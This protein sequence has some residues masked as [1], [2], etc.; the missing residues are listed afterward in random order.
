MLRLTLILLAL[1]LPAL[2]PA[3]A[4]ARPPRLFPDHASAVLE[5][6]PKGYARITPIARAQGAS[7]PRARALLEASAS[8]GDS[9]LAAR[10][11]AMLTQLPP[12]TDPQSIRRLQAF[13]AQ[14]RHDF[15]A[16]VSH[17]DA[18]LAQDPRDASARLS[19]AQVQ[20]VRGRLDLARR[21]CLGLA[22]GIDSGEGLICLAAWSL[23]RG[24]AA[25]A[26]LL[27]DRW[28]A[29]AGPT[30]P[31]RRFVLILRAEA[32]ARGGQSAD[33]W[34][35]L[36]LARAPQDVRSLAAYARYLRA[37]G[38]PRDALALLETAP[39]ADGLLLQ[40][41]LAAQALHTPGAPALVA[42]QA[43]RFREARRVGATIELRD[44]AEFLLATT[45]DASRPLALALENFKQQR[46][47]ED[48]DILLRSAR[49]AGRP[50]ALAPLQ[51]WARSQQLTLP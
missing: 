44:E 23:R 48:V 20:L 30:D 38:R 24:D 17:L 9:R 6:L 22:L 21:D 10:A 14:H 34:F 37:S 16:A 35:R 13:L 12:A 50:G 51:A 43:R 8:S 25:N 3:W 41:S 26:A 27:A 18:M 4:Q 1:V 33:A 31:S 42:A 7:L 28:L 29:Q 45:D 19:R 40:R 5:I 49:A 46:D 36:A 32:A 2:E 15:E 47:Y 11:E 39:R